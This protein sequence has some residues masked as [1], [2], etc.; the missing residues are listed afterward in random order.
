MPK[1]RTLLVGK[2]SRFSLLDG[3]RFAA[4]LGVVLFHFTAKQ[5]NAW[6]GRSV[7]EIFPYLHT[8]TSLGYYGVHLFF[9]ISGFVILMTAWG[10]DIPSYVA[11]RISRLYPAYIVS[12]LAVSTLLGAIWLNQKHLTVYQV[13]VNLTMTQGAFGIDHIDGVYW[14]LWVE[15]RFYILIGILM[16]VGLTRQ[17]ILAFATLWPI[18][19]ALARSTDDRFL[20]EALN[21]E[22][23]ALFAGGMAIYLLTR[24]HRDIAAWLVVALSALLAVAVPGQHSQAKL[25]NATGVGF[26]G[27]TT[28]V[29]IFGCFALVALV[30]LTPLKRVDVRWLTLLGLLTYPLY[31]IHEWWGWWMIHLLSGKLPDL[32]V[33]CITLVFVGGLAAGVYYV[34]ERPLGPRVRAITERSLRGL[35]GP[36]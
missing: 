31:L 1:P 3:L 26:S 14:T 36:R 19:G 23:S 16:L 22:Y 33:L 18:A 11:S 5:Q 2:H 6:G 20:I 25:E 9:V 27:H 28:A 10:K 7:P 24:N 15:L 21:A 30:T 29:V 8:F 35:S 34:V 13:A 12:V 4:A 17:R 32:L